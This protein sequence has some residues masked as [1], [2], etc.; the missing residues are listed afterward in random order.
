MELTVE[1]E[2]GVEKKEFNKGVIKNNVEM[3][4][5]MIKDAKLNILFLERDNENI[6]RENNEKIKRIQDSIAVMEQELEQDFRLSKETKIDTKDGYTSYQKLQD[7]YIYD[8]KLTITYCKMNNLP[9]IKVVE[10][11]E[12]QDLKGY[13]KENG[14][15]EFT[16]VTIEKQDP[17]FVYKLKNII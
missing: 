16:G 6:C 7:K 10:T 4:L 15:T 8:E 14:L 12:K 11:L 5:K 1:R 2:T 9:F 17:K 13:M 3:N